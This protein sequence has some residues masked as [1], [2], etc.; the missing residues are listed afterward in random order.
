[1]P[2]SH[3]IGG[4]YT[5]FKDTVR[6]VEPRWGT[7]FTRRRSS[8]LGEWVSVRTQGLE[9]DLVM[10]VSTRTMRERDTALS[11]AQKPLPSREVGKLPIISE[12][13]AIKTEEVELKKKIGPLSAEA[14][15]LLSHFKR[16]DFM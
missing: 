1:M 13:P 12:A 7:F 14:K 4:D 11:A 2:I 8:D 3:F 16:E 5:Y 9:Q 10:A 6:E 15:Q